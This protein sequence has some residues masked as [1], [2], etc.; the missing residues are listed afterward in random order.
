MWGVILFL[1][2]VL[3]IENCFTTLP[4]EY[5]KIH[6]RLAWVIAA[7]EALVFYCL[8]QAQSDETMYAV[9]GMSLLAYWL[10]R[11][12]VFVGTAASFRAFELE[13]DILLSRMVRPLAW[14]ASFIDALGTLILVALAFTTGSP[15][16]VSDGQH[17][18]D[19]SYGVLVMVAG[20]LMFSI[21]FL[22]AINGDKNRVS[23]WL[24]AERKK[25]VDGVILERKKQ[26]TAA[27]ARPK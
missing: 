21:V 18:S 11:G 27:T 3:A 20:G 7:P 13:N 8:A 19:L 1:P 23:A 4:P 25:Q 6:P 2:I 10:I 26:R 5:H 15:S 9:I 14:I 16:A 12:I 22:L 24:R 17:M